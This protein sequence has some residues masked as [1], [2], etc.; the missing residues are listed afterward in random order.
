MDGL[1]LKGLTIPCSTDLRQLIQAQGEVVGAFDDGAPAL[2]LGDQRHKTLYLAWRFFLPYS[3]KDDA[4]TKAA[5]R[6]LLQAF[7]DR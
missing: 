1:G 4:E 2:V 7:F 6:R 3:F 5:K